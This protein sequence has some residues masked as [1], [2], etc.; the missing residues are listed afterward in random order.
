[1]VDMV[2]EFAAGGGQVVVADTWADS[3]EVAHEYGIQLGRIDELSQVDALVVA[4][5]HTE[6]RQCTPA[7]LRAYCRGDQ[8]VLADVKSLYDRELA[9]QA[10]F[11]VFRL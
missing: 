3:E 4:V 2:R 6:Y 8:P 7:D 1:V 5:G 10:G 11:T 9:A